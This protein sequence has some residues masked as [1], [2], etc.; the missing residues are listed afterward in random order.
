MTFSGKILEREAP[1]MGVFVVNISRWRT[2]G[3]TARAREWLDLHNSA[4]LWN[5]GSQMPLWLTFWGHPEDLKNLPAEPAN[6]L[7]DITFVDAA[8]N[9]QGLGFLTDL[10]IA[11]DIA[12]ARILHWTGPRKP[13]LADGLYREVWHPHYLQFY[14]MHSEKKK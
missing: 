7:D 13:W 14:S 3:Y 8:W 2:L 1:N 6:A 10:S 5:G 9:F 4:P 11:E 12:E